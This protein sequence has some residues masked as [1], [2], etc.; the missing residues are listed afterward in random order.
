MNLFICICSVSETEP[1]SPAEACAL[2]CVGA[3]E[4][5]GKHTN[6]ITPCLLLLRSVP[7]H[8]LSEQH[9]LLTFDLAIPTL[10]LFV[11][12]SLSS[13]PL[14]LFFSYWAEDVTGFPLQR[15]FTAKLPQDFNV[16]ADRLPAM[17][18]PPLPVGSVLVSK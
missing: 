1:S 15:W 18:S 17:M 12:H 9:S 16:P 10:S 6:T 2:V 11:T 3:G 7:L 8:H 14:S 4:D 13:H 5:H